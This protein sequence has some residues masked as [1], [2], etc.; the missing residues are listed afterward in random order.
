MKIF[1][2]LVLTFLLAQSSYATLTAGTVPVTK[3]GGSSPVLQNGSISDTG[4][5]GGAGNV[6][7]GSSVPGATLDVQ[8]TTRSSFF[9]AKGDG[10]GV[11]YGP[12]GWQV[13]PYNYT[14]T[15]FAPTFAINPNGNIGVG[16]TAPGQT[17]DVRG[18]VKMTG[19]ILPTGAS[20]GYTLVSNSVGVGTWVPAGSGGGGSS[21][22]YW[23]QAGA[24]QGIGTTANVGIGTTVPSGK[25]DVE[26]VGNVNF[27]NFSSFVFNN[28]N[29]VTTTGLNVGISSASPG[30]TL[31]VQGTVRATNF[32]GTGSVGPLILVASQ[33]GCKLNSNITTGGGTDDSVCLQT[34]L[35][36]IAANSAGGELIIDG[37]A[38]V[39][40]VNVVSTTHD[41]IQASDQTSA[42]MVGNNTRIHI[43]PGGG[44]FLKA[45]SDCLLLGNLITGAVGATYQKNI[46]ID[47][48]VW[49]G[50]YANQDNTMITSG[51]DNGQ[52]F[53]SEKNLATN[54]NVV[55]FWF[56]S[57]DGLTI[58]DLSL[59]NSSVYQ[60]YFT[61]VTNVVLEN[62]KLI[63]NQS[64]EHGDGY[65]FGG[66]ISN[67]YAHNIS[68]TANT[69]D[70]ISF[71]TNE[72]Y[73][74]YAALG[75]YTGFY[76]T[77]YGAGRFPE[78]SSMGTVNNI[79]IDTAYENAG[80]G[81]VRFYAISATGSPSFDNITLK[82]IFGT[83]TLRIPLNT[84]SLF[85]VGKITIDG[86]YLPKTPLSVGSTTS[87]NQNIIIKNVNI[88][89][90][91]NN[92]STPPITL[93][94]AGTFNL[95]NINVN[96][97]VNTGTSNSLISFSGAANINATNLSTNYM[98]YL[99]TGGNASAKV[100]LS[101]VNTTNASGNTAPGFITPSTFNLI[102]DFNGNIGIGTLAP[103]NLFQVS[104]NIGI[105]STNVL[106]LGL[107]P[108]L[109]AQTGL[110]NYYGGDAGNLT[111]T[112]QYNTAFGWGAFS[113]NTSSQKNSFYGVGA[114][115]VITTGSFNAG[116]G[117]N[118]LLFD[119][120]GG[121]NTAVGN[122]ALQGILAGNN[123]AVGAQALGNPAST[124]ANDTS[125]GMLA[126]NY[127]NGFS[128]PLTLINNS[129][130][131]G[132]Q[133]EPLANGDTN[134]NVIG[135]NAIGSGLNTTT[136]GNSSTVAT[137]I[138][139][140]AMVIGNIGVGT[141]TP[142]AGAGLIVASGN[143]GIGSASPGQQL[144]VNGTIRT[145]NFTLTG[146]NAAQGLV[147]MASSAVGIGTWSTLPAGGG[148]SGTVN[149]GTAGQAAYYATS[150]TA[151]STQPDLV[152]N[153]S[154][155]GIGSVTPGQILDVQGTTRSTNFSLDTAGNTWANS[156]QIN[157]T[158]N[159]IAAGISISGNLLTTGNGS[160]IGGNSGTAGSSGI[161]VGGGTATSFL[162]IQPSAGTTNG[163][164][165]EIESGNHGGTAIKAM[166]IIDGGNVGIGSISPGQILDVKGT[167]RVVG[168]FIDTDIASASAGTLVCVKSNGGLGQCATLVGVICSSCT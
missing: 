143:V 59:I 98:K 8:G 28:I 47:G 40:N 21:S 122:A 125:L 80:N 144:D 72:E 44:V 39:S 18:T 127:Y 102:G 14:G 20:S 46:I 112:N 132:Y 31:D 26:S 164:Y 17:L 37:V 136:L 99:L 156:G 96:S 93:V 53:P 11:L 161:V 63:L 166:R 81:A 141:A 101:N 90:Y 126:G 48:G 42:L 88:D 86:W 134:E 10:P 103:Q 61:N 153:G 45:N 87:T 117:E 54:W 149:S 23:V 145:N 95:N 100:E 67:V 167:I 79:F 135:Y 118:A 33:Q 107:V 75:A 162:Q 97:T 159:L 15:S 83:S 35:N 111:G 94:G 27:N 157:M 119:L 115:N 85:T 58:R 146:N 124:S 19:F 147:L 77:A 57:V 56:G 123:T 71:N 9:T 130:F 7:I 160:F 108:M 55:G 16:T 43:I 51:P 150:T 142:A 139:A 163:G 92:G 4:S 168:D 70:F 133:A 6:G 165:V 52:Q 113:A 69:D 1:L 34:A 32:V 91:D 89:N 128:N 29:S 116:F 109:Q 24:N 3:T 25:F 62:T 22:N 105:G 152:F 64:N 140:G 49:N 12:D 104:G 65:H 36:K 129:V 121:S 5:S 106:N 73:G 137:V 30:A 74:W 41:P 50:N 120:T 151:V 148:G 82:N 110:N 76:G 60:M 78:S 154:N 84:G 68:A 66:N 138:P 131:I 13:D 114:G 38:L 158:G 2:V 155:V